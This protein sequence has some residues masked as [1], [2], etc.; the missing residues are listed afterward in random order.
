MGALMTICWAG[1]RPSAI[2]GSLEGISLALERRREGNR[3]E[4]KIRATRAE[5]G[6][7]D[8]GADA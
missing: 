5:K 7:R 6:E 8:S 4:K 3:K 1:D 2:T